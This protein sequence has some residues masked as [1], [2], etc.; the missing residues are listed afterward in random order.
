M[1]GLKSSEKCPVPG[2]SS[3]APSTSCG[4]LAP[5]RTASASVALDTIAPRMLREDQLINFTPAISCAG[6]G[7]WRNNPF[8]QTSGTSSCFI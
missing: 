4:K 6:P 1:S 7:H 5:S 3:K 2:S 8:G